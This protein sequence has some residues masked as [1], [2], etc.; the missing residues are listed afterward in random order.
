[1]KQ[2]RILDKKRLMKNATSAISILVAAV[3]IFS[4][5]VSATSTNAN[6]SLVT[7]SKIMPMEAPIQSDTEAYRPSYQPLDFQT[8]L[9]YHTGQTSGVGFG[10]A[11]VFEMAMRLTPT[12]LT[13]YDGY[14]L[15]KIR[16]HSY[17]LMATSAVIKIYDEGTATTAGSLLT[18]QPYTIT[19]TGWNEV[20][21]I[22]PPIINAAKDIWVS[23]ELDQTAAG[24]PGGCDNGPQ[25]VDKGGFIYYSGGWNQLNLLGIDRNWCIEAQVAEPGAIPDHDVAV[26]SI[27]APTSGPAGI[28][29]PECT[30]KNMGNNSE[31]TDVQFDIG[32]IGTASQVWSYGF[33]DWTIA[34]YTHPGWTNVRTVGV[35][36]QCYWEGHGIG[37]SI[38]PSVT[39]YGGSVCAL[40]DTGYITNY[41]QTRV[42]RDTS[43]DFQAMGGAVYTLKGMF[44][45]RGY[46][47][48]GQAGEI[49]VQMSTDGSTWTTAG[50]IDM[51]DASEYY[52]HWVEDQVDLTPWANEPVVYLAFLGVDGGYSDIL[53]D[54][55]SIW[56]APVI[57]EW[58]A[59][60]TV[61]L[62]VGEIKTVTFP[63]WV[64]SDWQVSE[65]ID[66][67]YVLKAES[68]LS[69]DVP[70]NDE[71]AGL[72][73]YHF[74]YL[75]D[76][77]VT[78][79]EDPTSNPGQTLP[80]KAT[81]T[82]IGQNAE[83]CHTVTARIGAKTYIDKW[84]SV[85][86]SGTGE[87]IQMPY[88][89]GG[90]QPP[91]GGGSYFAGCDSDMYAS[92]VY[93][94]GLFTYALDL[95]G[96]TSVTIG[97]EMS[98]V[99]YITD[100]AA[101]RVYSGGMAP[102]NLE[103][104][105]ATYTATTYQ[106]Y[107][108]FVINPS[109]YSNPG[110]VYVE[111]YYTTVGGTYQYLFKIDDV[112]V[113]PGGLS[114][115]FEGTVFPPGTFG[116]LNEYTQSVMSITLDPG[117]T[118]QLTFPS[119]TPAHLSS[120]LSENIDYQVEVEQNL[121][122]DTNPGNDV[123]TSDITL[124][125][126]HDYYVEEITAPAEGGRAPGDILWYWDATA[127]HGD[128]QMLGVEWDGT[129]FYLT[130]AGGVATPSPNY[131]YRYEF[132]GTYVD[133]VAQPTGETWGW[134]DIA[135]DGTHMYSSDST[136]VVEW[137][138]TGP[139][140]SPTLNIHATH[141]GV[142]PVSPARALAYDPDT[143]HFWTASF[144][145]SFY[146]FDLTGT[147]HN[148]FTNPG[149]SAYGFAWDDL[150]DDGPWLWCNSQTG[151]ACTIDQIDPAT[152]TQTGTSYSYTQGI[153]GG[154]CMVDQGGLGQFVGMTQ[155]TPDEV[156]SIEICETG[157][158]GPPTPDIFL[159]PGSQSISCVIENG[160]TFPETGM[161]VNAQIYEYIT[162]FPNGTL[163][164]D[165][166]YTC[167][168]IAPLGG[169][170]T[171]TFP[172]YT[173]P[174]AAGIYGLVFTITP[175]DDVDNNEEILGIG[176]DNDP[177]NS[178]HTITPA[179]PDGLNDWYIS[180]VTLD[181]TADDGIEVWQ[182]G[183]DY[184]EYKVD[185]AGWV[186]GNTVTVTTDGLHTVQY[187]AVDE[188]GNVESATSVD[189]KIDKTKPT[190]DLTW[191]SPDNVNVDFVADAD[192][193]TSGMDYVEFYLNLGLMFTDN[194]DPYEWSI[195]WSPSLKTAVF[196]AKA[197][198]MAGHFE[199]D[200]ETGIEAVPVPHA[201]PTPQGQQTNP[202]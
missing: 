171:A 4:S 60:E 17:D 78:S 174:D 87:W 153:A 155:G 106:Q 190:V 11:I 43:F 141:S 91:Y 83:C 9:Y 157:P 180:D 115:G 178:A 77:E 5:A 124:S 68:L 41:G 199:I 72:C 89:A 197:F 7:K 27:D 144:T 114:E 165:E 198:D 125:Y 192:D 120:G 25:V 1:M 39:V 40:V 23:I 10:G 45:K 135:Y 70:A 99:H 185:T 28:V 139:A 151:S 93:D 69:D 56:V 140:G 42:S 48:S 128:D 108:S 201:T 142:S 66:V 112:T 126:W 160:G 188:V 34:G 181:F 146:E 26:L 2:T 31:V 79:I 196:T 74:P 65:N 95:T 183:V 98:F 118:H 16:W 149:S 33:E 15:N 152:G 88:S 85:V 21:I 186:S 62:A 24:F 121:P 131:V 55:I 75:H 162:A 6:Q 182:S 111:F 73:T 57:P 82:N 36:P 179:T 200:E 145:S 18:S 107:E 100:W 132:D 158:P 35:D 13:G 187:R 64:P 113:T 32:T 80:V 8:W 49:K 117:D 161:N 150:S 105:L 177:P 59:T 63:L 202:L 170:E 130:G 44:H 127:A 136:D 101:V 67:S 103:Q 110:E 123:L 175:L 176:I 58:S 137:S 22:S 51:Y 189:F 148:T 134:R 47:G 191:S 143:G 61:S 19:S 3:L 156:F 195:V 84:Q 71:K 109:T 164:Y 167:G 194:S 52:G 138:V 29:A 37:N 96:E 122:G 46:G 193:A 163:V 169:Q 20:A 92:L 166:N 173:F 133:R 168:T 94:C 154:A 90:Y 184:I 104:T 14:E 53:M 116:V 12:E 129:Y 97:Y 102:G 86:Y 119:W 38:Y 147:V 172:S 50:T 76:V 81:I 159:Q 30:V 54:N